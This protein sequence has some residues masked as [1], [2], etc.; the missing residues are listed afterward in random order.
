MACC[1]LL[2]HLTCA[3]K[4]SWIEFEQL[5]IQITGHEESTVIVL[6]LLPMDSINVHPET[7]PCF[8]LA[9]N[10][11]FT[12][13]IAAKTD[14]RISPMTGSFSIR[15]IIFRQMTLKLGLNYLADELHLLTISTILTPLQKA[16][17]S[18]SCSYSPKI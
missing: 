4:S 16:G 12:T 2:L 3:V 17:C 7:H 8:F 10:H 15:W 1:Q 5:V 9:Q 18:I 13:A 14:H 6:P 11:L